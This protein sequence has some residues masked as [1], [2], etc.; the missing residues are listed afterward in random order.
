MDYQKT[1]QLIDRYFEG[2]TT[3]QQEAQLKAYFDGAH[4]DPRLVEYQPLFLVL[5][6]QDTPELD[7][8]FDQRMTDMLSDLPADGGRHAKRRTLYRFVAAASVVAVLATAVWLS[9]PVKNEATAEADTIDWSKY[10]P[11]S[12]EE[13]LQVYR[14]ALGQV[15][16]SLQKGTSKARSTMRPLEEVSKFFN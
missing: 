9:L 2:N 3:L 6:P 13:A 12:Q 15:G 16:K 7:E 11:A 5:Q 8:K 14:Q 4:I 1:K 10:E